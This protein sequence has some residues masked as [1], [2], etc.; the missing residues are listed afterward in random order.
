M[1]PFLFRNL[2]SVM[3]YHFEIKDYCLSLR[4]STWT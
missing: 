2:Q 4:K 1:S 3:I